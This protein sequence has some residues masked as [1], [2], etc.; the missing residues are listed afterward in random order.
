M[1]TVNK[2]TLCAVNLAINQTNQ[3]HQ[4]N[5][6][7][8]P[9]PLKVE[10]L[11]ALMVNIVGLLKFLRSQIN[12][13]ENAM[14]SH[15]VTK[16]W[17]NTAANLAV[18]IKRTNL[19]PHPLQVMMLAALTVICVLI[20]ILICFQMIQLENAQASHGVTKQWQ[21]TAANLAVVIQRKSQKQQSVKM[22]TTTAHSW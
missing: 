14:V 18:E 20:F 11:A 15:G 12:L 3:R 17:Q 4:L 2:W 22:N 19:L 13:K 9:H 16:L 8:L 7:N 10:M 21:N 5:L 1:L 6:N